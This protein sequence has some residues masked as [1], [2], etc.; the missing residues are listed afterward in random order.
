MFEPS[1]VTGIC[2]HTKR[3]ILLLWTDLIYCQKDLSDNG[4]KTFCE[5]FIPDIPLKQLNVNEP[6]DERIFMVLELPSKNRQNNLDVLCDAINFITEKYS[7]EG[8][9]KILW[10]FICTT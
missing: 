7:L 8:I 1:G 6:T 4:F 3:S 9:V 5:E 2:F 10:G